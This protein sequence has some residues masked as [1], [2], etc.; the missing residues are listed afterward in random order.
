MAG[1]LAVPECADCLGRLVVEA[2]K[3]LVHV[4]CAEG[5]HEPFA[6]EKQG[7]LGSDVRAGRER[8]KHTCMGLGG[9]SWL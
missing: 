3:E 6:K 7:V 4:G 5:L 1:A 8:G 2:R 9:R